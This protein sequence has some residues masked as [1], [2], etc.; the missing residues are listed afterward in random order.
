MGW[1]INGTDIVNVNTY[2]ITENTTFKA[3]FGTWQLL[4]DEQ[5]YVYGEGRN[6]ETLS[7]NGLKAGDKIKVTANYIKTNISMESDAYMINSPDGNGCYGWAYGGNGMWCQLDQY[8]NVIDGSGFA[9]DIE[10]NSMNDFTSIM[11]YS[12]YGVENEFTISISCKK[13]GV[14]TIEW[15]DQAGG[16][17]DTMTMWGV[18]VL[19]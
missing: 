14:L 12:D 1:T 5:F 8:G 10:F 7:V 18:Y 11:G 4:T 6:Q 13:D 15:S 17:I 3:K 19:R 16:Y 9:D 2:K